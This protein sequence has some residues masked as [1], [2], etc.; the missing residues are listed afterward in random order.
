[1]QS[2]EVMEESNEEAISGLGPKYRYKR[3]E[4]VRRMN[5]EAY[6]ARV[7]DTDASIKATWRNLSTKVKGLLKREN[8]S[9]SKR[10]WPPLLDRE[11]SS[12]TEPDVDV[13]PRYFI[14]K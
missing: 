13:V 6:Y 12:D 10:R 7:K 1:M 4:E 3:P 5:E 14:Q 11:V 8:V 9:D 2:P